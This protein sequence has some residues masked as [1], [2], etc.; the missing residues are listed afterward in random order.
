MVNRGSL[1]KDSEERDSH[2]FPKGGKSWFAVESK[3]FE[4]SIEEIRG[5]L[6]GTI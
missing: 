6:R 5:R 1:N 3:S 4:I 2:G